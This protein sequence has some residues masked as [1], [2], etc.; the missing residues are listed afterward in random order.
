MGRLSPIFVV[1]F[2]V[3][4]F[5]LVKVVIQVVKKGDIMC[6]REYNCKFSYLYSYYSMF[7]KICL[8]CVW[9]M[10]CKY[11]LLFMTFWAKIRGLESRINPL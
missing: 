1:S 8:Q 4:V 10:A 7:G 11:S 3:F 9:R 2:V 5:L 6:E